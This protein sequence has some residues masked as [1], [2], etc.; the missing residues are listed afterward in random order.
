M[1]VATLAVKGAGRPRARR[2]KTGEATRELKT[3]FSGQLHAETAPGC[4]R[5][6]R[7]AGGGRAPS[8]SVRAASPGVRRLV[9]VG[10]RPP[11]ALPPTPRTTGV[12]WVAMTTTRPPH[13]PV[14]LRPP[15][16]PL[17]HHLRF[18]IVREHHLS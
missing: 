14:S 18:E 17:P 4:G 16:P 5:E 3:W 7:W 8:H 10:G 1:V 15:L 9:G 11:L 2:G 12:D 6:R 13:L